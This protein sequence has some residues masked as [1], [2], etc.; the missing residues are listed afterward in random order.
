MSGVAFFLA[1]IVTNDAPTKG[2]TLV[3]IEM[4]A[5]E[6][7]TSHT[8][9][10]VDKVGPVQVF[11]PVLIRVVGVGTTIKVIRRRI[12]TTLLVTCIL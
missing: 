1:R 2:S 9:D 12:F 6:F 8:T 10:R 7:M 3:G 11:E 4:V 5:A